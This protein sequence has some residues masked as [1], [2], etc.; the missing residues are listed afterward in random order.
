[1]HQGLTVSENLTTFAK[2]IGVPKNEMEV[3]WDQ[4]LLLHL[5]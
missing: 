5:L 2:K 3:R 4:K 1:M